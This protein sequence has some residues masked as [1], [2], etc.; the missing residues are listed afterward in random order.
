MEAVSL[1]VNSGVLLDSDCAALGAKGESGMG[2]RD[3]KVA[4]IGLG[5]SNIPLIR[6]LVAEGAQITVCDRQKP[7]EMES[8]LSQ[9]A[10]LPVSYKLGGGYLDDLQGFDAVFLSPGIPKD[11]P[12]IS[13]LRERGVKLSSEMEVFFQLCPAPIAG[14]T[15]SSGKTTTTT[16]V[17]EI[18][19][20]QGEHQVLVGGNIGNSLLDEIPN[21]S[22]EDLVVL[23]LSSFQLELLPYSPRY[24]LV[25]NI[26]PNHLDMHR[27]MEAY[28]A[29]KRHIFAFQGPD[30][31]VVLNYDNPATRQLKADCRGQVFF[32]SR[33]E[34]PTRGAFLRNGMITVRDVG[35]AQ[36]KE[37]TLCSIGA[38]RL[39]GVHNWEN[40][41][42]AVTLSA[43][44]G[45]TPEAIVKVIA[46][47]TGVP[48]RLEL[49]EVIRGVK[50]YNDSIATSPARA[51]AG[52]K[53]FHEPI[54]LIAGG[55]DKQ[56]SF[57]ELA[58]TVNERVKAVVL[59]G[60]TAEKIEAAI[61]ERRQ[62]S[63]QPV[64]CRSQDF[65]SAVL[66]ASQLAEAGDVVLMSPACASYD[67]FRNFEERGQR[68][69]DLVKAMMEKRQ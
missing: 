60:T 52:I 31:C 46:T 56:L 34:E 1:K 22:A 53:A 69:R 29:A 18:L 47:F 19:A 48:H 68:F 55:Y 54:V 58:E 42:A 4:V 6:Y 51:I 28:I 26:T 10:G 5:I 67:M 24:A 2:W 49:V 35:F 38:V 17:G 62:R 45:A 3:R 8:R 15:G 39:L 36:G 66:K 40:V 59:V 11:L 13:A 33:L 44:C 37:V 32:F 50:Y 7:T 57:N 64:I 9:I 23:E 43:L 27:N 65:D 21:M 20:A 12:E 14:I 63:D 41:L 25:T 61:R 16:L 30:D